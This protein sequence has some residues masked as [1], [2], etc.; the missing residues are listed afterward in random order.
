MQDS[1]DQRRKMG[2]FK[3]GLDWVYRSVFLFRQ[4]P[5]KWLLHALLYATLFIMLPSIPVM[6]VLISLLIILFWPTFLALFMGVFREADLGRDTEPRE[7][8]EEIKPNF[9]KLITLG[10]V[11]LAY[12]ILTGVMV[13]DEMVELNALVA[14]KAEAEIVM[15]QLLPLI[16]K[17]LLILTPMIMASWFSPM[18]VGFQGYGVLEAIKHSF[19]QCGR[20]LIAIIVAWSILSMS[21]FLVLLIAGLFVG[22]ISA[23][24]ALL[25]TFLMSLVV[26]AMLL[27]VTYFLLAI[28]YYSY[29]HVYYHPEAM[30]EAAAD[31]ATV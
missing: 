18:L 26:F 16:F 20:N 21:L 27:L 1:G 15:Q 13:R 8:V 9:V 24:S 12:G 23:I 19:W 28:Q 29:R 7:L 11:F 31:D 14:G 22:I 25:G 10:G 4:N 5:P 17:M 2:A 3:S 30:A 6:P